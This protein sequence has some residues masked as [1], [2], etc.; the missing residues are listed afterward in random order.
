MDR[1]A[2]HDVKAG[3]LA[4][5]RGSLEQ[6]AAQGIVVRRPSETDIASL[7]AHFS[8]MQAHY[9]RPVSNEVALKAA[10]LACKTPVK[11]FDPRVLVALADA[12]IV[13]SVVMNATF[14]ASDLSRSL[15]IR[16][17]Y[18]ANAARRSGVGRMLVE[19]AMRLRAAEGFSALEWTTDSSNAVARRLYETC[20]ARKMDRT[21]FNERRSVARSAAARSRN[22]G[23]QVLESD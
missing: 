7:A 1:S 15:Y 23:L 17:L 9:N 12:K 16:D 6:P 10:T 2:T 14:P 20:G 4:G 11:A 21:Y 8:E 19:A 3:D 22:R 13:G 18:V 5:P